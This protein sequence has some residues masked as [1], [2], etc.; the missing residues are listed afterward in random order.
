MAKYTNG[1]RVGKARDLKMSIRR[2]DK[3]ASS[4]ATYDAMTDTGGINRLAN[5]LDNNSVPHDQD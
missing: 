5:M 2:D 4:Y 3:N 1:R